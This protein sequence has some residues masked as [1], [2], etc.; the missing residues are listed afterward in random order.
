MPTASRM[1]K[2][3]EPPPLSSWSFPANLA[4]GRPFHQSTGSGPSP[5]DFS[6]FKTTVE[7]S[8]CYANDVMP[9]IQAVFPLFMGTGD[10]EIASCMTGL[11]PQA[12][13]FT[14]STTHKTIPTS[15]LHW[16]RPA[17]MDCMAP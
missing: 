5:I 13:T 1:K 15:S 17:E 9:T 8:F 7:K 2:K 10:V 3:R 4:V 11:Y 16:P 6:T 14:A 12:D